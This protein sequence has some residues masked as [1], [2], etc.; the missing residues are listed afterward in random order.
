MLCVFSPKTA[1]ARDSYKFVKWTKGSTE[2]STNNPYSFTVTED[3]ELVAHFESEVGIGELRVTSYELQVYPNPT[4]GEI[5]VT[6]YELQVTCVEVFDVFGRNVGV[7][8]PSFGGVGG[9]DISHLPAGIYF[10]RIQTETGV[11]TRK[12]VKQ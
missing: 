7:K 5:Q 4:R 1:T 8:L 2:V 12:V 11:V 9:G 3:V 6:S 10:L